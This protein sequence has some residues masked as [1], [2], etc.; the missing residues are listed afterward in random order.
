M[1]ALDVRGVREGNA[2][3]RRRRAD[4]DF[5]AYVLGVGRRIAQVR[6]RLGLTQQEAAD[7]ARMEL[8]QWQ[9]LERGRTNPTLQTMFEAAAA[10][11][12]S[13]AALAR[14]RLERAP[15]PARP[16]RPT[17]RTRT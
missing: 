5:L 11:E 7:R 17:R 14:P 8:T 15:N 13:V 12:T 3:R 16:G 1:P 2:S 6:Q 9:R 4:A 10:L